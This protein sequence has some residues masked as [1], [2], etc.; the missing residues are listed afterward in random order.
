[1]A[2][3]QPPQWLDCDHGAQA[4]TVSVSHQDVFTFSATLVEEVANISVRCYWATAVDSQEFLAQRKT[5]LTGQDA[6]FVSQ[7]FTR[8]SMGLPST[9]R[10]LRFEF[11]SAYD[12]VVS[13]VSVSK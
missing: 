1:L 5:N 8:A 7:S 4:Y 3:R 2:I 10:I 13:S 11:I 9:A 6:L 12:G